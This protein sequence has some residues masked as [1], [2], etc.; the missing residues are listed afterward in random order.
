MSVRVALT[1]YP[2][3]FQSQ[4]GVAIQVLETVAALTKLGIDARF[5]DACCD[6]LVDFDLV[7]VFAAVH[8]NH[9]IVGAAKNLGVPVVLSPI[10]QPPFSKWRALTSD[11]CDRLTGRLTRWAVRTTYGDIRSALQGADRIV[12]LG[13]AERQIVAR[14]YGID[15]AK[16]RLV[17]N[18][19]SAGY[20]L[21]DPRPF[22]ENRGLRQKIVLSVAHI[23]AYKNQ[24]GLI[25][26]LRNEPCDI[27]LIGECRPISREYLDQCL[28]LGGQQ[29]HYLG[30][31]DH[32]DPMLASAYAAADVMVLA[33]KT[34]VAPL[35]VLE[36]LAA[37]T[38]VV[39]T[40]H[41]SLD[42]E[43]DGE[44]LIS[45]NPDDPTKIR[46]SVQRL[47]DRPPDR[48]DCSAAVTG[49]TW[50]ATANMLLKIYSEVIG[51]GRD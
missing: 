35:A 24:L 5:F 33:S 22:L 14:H 21:A 34:E 20:F 11:F 7:H 17:P 36:S 45:V 43:T 48:R 10:L 25:R 28:S 8:G 16:I 37:G 50:D 26:A 23:S 46:E 13:R 2:V 1:S 40:E 51:D 4:G 18:G 6:K 42:L 41:N 19:V 9:T 12:V 30:A 47:L 3:A 32:T 27:V 29:V 44:V 38:P 39:L 15:S 49:L 31:I